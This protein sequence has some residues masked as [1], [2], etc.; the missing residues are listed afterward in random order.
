MHTLHENH[1][2]LILNAYNE[3]KNGRFVLPNRISEKDYKKKKGDLI[4]I[5]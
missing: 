4:Y 3:E 2:R 1:D 5:A